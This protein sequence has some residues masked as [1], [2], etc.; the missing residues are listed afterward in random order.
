MQATQAPTGAEAIESRGARQF[1]LLDYYLTSVLAGIR[2][3]PGP[4]PKQALARIVNPLSYPRYMEYRLVMELLGELDGGPILDIGSPKLP[5]LLLA[6]HCPSEIFATDIRDYFIG[7]TA[8]LLRRTGSGARLDADVH[9]ETQDARSLSYA[10]SSFDRVFSV[11]V[12]EHIPDNGDA[13]AAR[14]I[15]RVLRPGGIA[16]STV[17]FRAEG[18]RDEYVAGDVFER[19]ASGGRTFFQRRYDLDTLRTRLIEPS[20]LTVTAI[21]P[22]G[23]P[24]VPFERAW[25]RIPMKWKV[26]VLWAAPFIAQ[27]FLRRLPMSRIDAACGIALRLSKPPI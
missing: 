25:N 9:L 27:G 8:H 19:R 26:P 10:D 17:P 6:K 23:E 14:E 15:A 21:I 18:Y 22:F 5:I 2:A 12:L 4:Y 24:I 16:A 7:P 1:G 3:L 20:G 11:S 13:V